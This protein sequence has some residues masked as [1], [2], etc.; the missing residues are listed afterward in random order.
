VALEKCVVLIPLAFNDGR[1]VPETVVQ[2][3]LD[4]LWVEFGGFFVA[5]TGSGAYRMSDGRRRDDDCLEVW[6]GVPT[7]E[8]SGVTR[9]R[10]ICGA[11][12]EKLGQETI[13]FERTGAKIEFIPPGGGLF[14]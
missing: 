2:G 1:S 12:A 14:K 8:G 5:G 11:M 4:Q 3:L 9:L 13:Y 10:A 7:E 6:V